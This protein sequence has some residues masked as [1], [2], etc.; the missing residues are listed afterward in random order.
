MTIE[1]LD[2]YGLNEAIYTAQGYSQ[3]QHHG[4]LIWCKECDDSISNEYLFFPPDYS[5]KINKAWK[6]VE[7]MAN[8]GYCVRV[9]TPFRLDEHYT[10]KVDK[11]GWGD[12]NPPP[13]GGWSDGDTVCIAICRI[14]LHWKEYLGESNEG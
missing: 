4:D 3:K 5:G 9:S 14:W 12:P 11:M 8:K 7:D 13:P 1:D 2:C 10:V 6:L